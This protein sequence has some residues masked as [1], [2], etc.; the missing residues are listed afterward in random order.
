MRRMVL[1]ILIVAL[2]AVPITQAQED[3]ETVKI[4]VLPFLSYGPLYI[5]RDMGFFE[6]E[7]ITPEFVEATAPPT[8]FPLII[9]GEV[10]VLAGTV[11]AA[12]FNAVARG[13]EIRVVAD[14]GSI[15][16]DDACDHSIIGVRKELVESGEVSE[17]PDLAG[18]TI[19]IQ[20]TGT[21]GYFFEQA[22]AEYDLTLDDFNVTTIPQGDALQGFISGSMDAGWISD[23]WIARNN[24]QETIEPFLRLTEFLEDEAF[25]VIIYGES[26][27][28]ADSD[29]GTRFMRAYLRG[30]GQF[31]DGP[32]EENVEI[33]SNAINLDAD[34]LQ[35][36]CWTA[37]S[38]DGQLNVESLLGYQDWALER[39]YLDEIVAVED[40]WDERFIEEAAQS[41]ED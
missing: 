13:A 28:S 19:N 39:D 32:T 38:A 12:V 30:V 40:F 16:A 34:I 37:I 33:L 17:I 31:L 29:V 15:R 7:G 6:E 8:L 22:L 20:A 11:S 5:A 27:L 26:M 36:A 25:S 24:Q 41:L 23:P 4:G 14:K 18:R 10:D 1:L 21:S 35:Q 2:S 9:D 3:N